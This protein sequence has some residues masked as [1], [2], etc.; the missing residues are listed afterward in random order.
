[1]AVWR[2]LELEPGLLVDL[3]SNGRALTKIWFGSL[4]LPPEDRDDNHPIL[5]QATAE[6]R[7]YMAGQREE[8]TVPLELTGTSFQRE[9]WQ[10]L[11]K[12]PYGKT[13]RYIDIANAIGKPKAVRAVGAANGSNPVPIIVPCHRVIGSDGTLTGYGG[14]LPLKRRLLQLEGILLL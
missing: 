7:E 13:C 6:L 2:P 4:G 14:G 10:E 9:V 8:F 12:I 1:M 5:R 11:C 3:E